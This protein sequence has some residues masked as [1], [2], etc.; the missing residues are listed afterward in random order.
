MA[1][2]LYTLFATLALA[3]LFATAVGVMVIFFVSR[4]KREPM[5]T[6]NRINHIR[7]IWWAIT[8]PEMFVKTFEWLA[9]DEGD[10]MRCNGEIE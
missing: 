7:L 5:D 8:K 9:H 10:N 2:I 3:G 6:S 4:A 1:A